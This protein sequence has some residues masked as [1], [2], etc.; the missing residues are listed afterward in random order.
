MS[1]YSHYDCKLQI[2]ILTI[3]SI[4]NIKIILKKKKYLSRI[5]KH[6]QNQSVYTCTYLQYCVTFFCEVLPSNG[7][8]SKL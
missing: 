5:L 3:H 2:R 1:S 4:I 7:S 6:G 8:I